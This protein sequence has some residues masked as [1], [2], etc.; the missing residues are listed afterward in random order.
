M[1][2]DRLRSNKL[3]SPSL[4]QIEE[5]NQLPHAVSNNSTKIFYETQ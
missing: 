1:K 4:R 3:L 2:G 5:K